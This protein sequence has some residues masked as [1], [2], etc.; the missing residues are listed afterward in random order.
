[1]EIEAFVAFLNDMGFNAHLQQYM[2]HVAQDCRDGVCFGTN[3]L[4]KN[5][6]GQQPLA[7]VDYI[8]KNRTVFR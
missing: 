5:L 3:E 1:M 7:M 2:V 6:T 8:V 4:V